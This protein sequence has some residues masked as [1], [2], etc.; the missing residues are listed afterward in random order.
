M[1]MYRICIYIYTHTHVYAYIHTH[2]CVNVCVCVSI[3]PART[4]I[5]DCLCIQLA[6]RRVSPLRDRRAVEAG[7]RPPAADAPLQPPQPPRGGGCARPRQGAGERRRDGGTR[8]G[9]PGGRERGGRR[10]QRRGARSRG[11]RFP[12]RPRQL[13]RE[14]RRL[15]PRDAITRLLPRLALQYQTKSSFSCSPV[16]PR[17]ELT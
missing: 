5:G 3:N 12:P 7:C 2:I 8:G 1:H 16:S 13:R 6:L 4:S 17:R 9:R 10:A 14:R 11:G 15:K